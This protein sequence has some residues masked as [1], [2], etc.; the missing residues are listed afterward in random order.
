MEFYYKEAIP[1][2]MRLAGQQLCGY[3][4]AIKPSEAEKNIAAEMAA[5]EAAAAQQARL[6]E[7]EEWNGAG[8]TSPSKLRIFLD[9]LLIVLVSL[10]GSN[11]L[12]FTKLYVGSIHFSISEDD[13]RTIFEPFGEVI[14]LQLHKDPETGRSRGFGFVQY[15]NH[16]DAKKALEQLNGLDLAGRPLKVGDWSLTFIKENN[17]FIGW[18]SYCRSSKTSG[19]RCHSFWCSWNDSC[20]KFVE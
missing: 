5:R 1:S 16:E 12:T 10:L 17:L 6:A 9:V 7:L 8:D 2:A 3:P 11:P 13:L 4:V 19:I 20:P 15:K 14:S 18:F